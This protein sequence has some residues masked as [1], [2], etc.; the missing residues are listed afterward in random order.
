MKIYHFIVAI[1]LGGILS[2]CSNEGSVEVT[3]NAVI[4]AY[5]VAGQYITMHVKR[6]PL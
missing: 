6:N 2:S 4:E 3:D 5:L 1:L